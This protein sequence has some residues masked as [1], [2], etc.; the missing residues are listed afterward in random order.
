MKSVGHLDGRH[1]DEAKAKLD[2]VHNLLVNKKHVHFDAK[3]EYIEPAEEK[4]Y[5]Y[6]NGYGFDGYNQRFQS[7]M[8]FQDNGSFIRNYGASTYQNPPA[9]TSE[10]WI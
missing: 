5:K 8:C 7:Q 2:L 6:L 1:I 9:I 4:D 10:I 3:V